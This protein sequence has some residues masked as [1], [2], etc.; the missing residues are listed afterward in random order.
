MRAEVSA[1]AVLGGAVPLDIASVGGAPD[2]TFFWPASDPEYQAISRE[3]PSI[4]VQAARAAA[5]GDAIVA[6]ECKLGDILI[7][8]IRLARICTELENLKRADRKPLF[9]RQMSPILAWIADGASGDPSIV[10]R[11]WP[12]RTT[13]EPWHSALHNSGLRAYRLLRMFGQRRAYDVINAN[14]LSSEF[15]CQAGE[16]ASNLHPRLFRWPGL[17]AAHNPAVAEVSQAIADAFSRWIEQNVTL[18]PQLKKRVVASACSSAAHH[19]TMALAD[20]S[21]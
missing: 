4:C 5:T 6:I 11:H 13:A 9:D 2:N 12:E 15:L 7:D 19:L 8:L 17:H 14:I 21:Y 16:V 1:T 10:Y 3:L 18:S 20:M